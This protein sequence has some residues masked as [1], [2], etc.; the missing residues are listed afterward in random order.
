MIIIGGKRNCGKTTELIKISS[1][2][3]IPILVSNHKRG[4]IIEDY[5]KRNNFKI[6]EPIA[7]CERDKIRG[8][9]INEILIDDL[10]DILC[11]LLWVRPMIIST[12]SPFVP[13]DNVRK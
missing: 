11:E 6:P 9:G 8:S 3:N 5:A 12:S 13:M 1:V 10:E 7:F 4:K 2:N